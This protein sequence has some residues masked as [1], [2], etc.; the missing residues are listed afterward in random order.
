[1]LYTKEISFKDEFDVVVC[2]GGFSG[3]AAAYSAARD[4]ARVILV[5]RESCLGGVGTNGHVNHIL[6]ARGIDGDKVTDCVMGL[7]AKL[8]SVLLER[9]ACVDYNK[10]ELELHPH[11]WIPFLGVGIVFDPEK[12]KLIL[13]EMLE[14]LNVKILYMTDI[15][16]VIKEGDTLTGIVVHN[17]SGVYAIG[18]KYFVDTTG[19]ADICKYS[20]LKMYKGDEEGGLAAASLEVHYEDVDYK[21]LFDYMKETNDVR[22]RALINKLKE[23]GEWTFPYEIFISVMLTKKDVCFINTIRQ[24]GIDGTDVESIT[25]GIIDGRKENF[26]LLEIARKHFPGFKN[27]KMRKVANTLGVRETNRIEGEYTLTVN[28]LLEAVD[29]DDTVALSGYG[30]DMP[31]PKSPSYQPFH[32]VK[33][34][35]HITPIPYRCLLP[36]GMKNLIV[37]GRCISVE[38]EVMGPTRVMGPCIAMGEAAGIATGMALK[39]NKS[40]PDVDVTELRKKIVE[41]GGHVDRSQV[42]VIRTFNK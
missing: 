34:K 24:V 1:M 4:G 3:F 26:D 36:K 2:G 33:R 40:Y 16:D 7:H 5:E 31:N 9:N 25:R 37:A 8:E 18:G 14:S 32:G 27:A 28:D 13:E 21:E 15:I 30:W 17:K 23:T 10:T 11:G 35:S 6:G 39:E 38:R 41:Y 20:G 42:K 29:F 19:D 12:M 22:F